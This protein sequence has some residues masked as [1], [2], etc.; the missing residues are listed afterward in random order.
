MTAGPESV[1]L[2]FLWLSLA[3][4]R[5]LCVGLSIVDV[6]DVGVAFIQVVSPQGP[7]FRLHCAS[8]FLCWLPERC[9]CLLS[10]CPQAWCCIH[11]V[12]GVTGGA[13]WFLGVVVGLDPAPSPG[14]CLPSA[15]R[16]GPCKAVLLLGPSLSPLGPGANAT[17][18]WFSALPSPDK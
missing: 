18:C 10:C 1:L 6:V 8:A 14:A 5:Q 3:I 12:L 13:A 11:M 16:G 2:V 7:S 9:Q 15:D 4:Q 17:P